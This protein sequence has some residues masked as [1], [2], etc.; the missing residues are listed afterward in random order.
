MVSAEEKIILAAISCI[1]KYGIDKTTIR[2][3]GKEAGVNSASISYYFRSKEFLMQQVMDVTLENAFDMGNFEDSRDLPAKERLVCILEGMLAG[4]MKFPNIT[5]AFF[6]ELLAGNQM[7]APVVKKCNEFIGALESELKSAYP[8]MATEDIR[9]LL[10]QAASSTF[11]FPGLFPEFFGGFPEVDFSN[12]KIRKIYVEKLIS[13][14][15]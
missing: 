3:I 11:L 15:L 10:I 1:E 8:D 9:M 13:K 4:A 14:L 2:Q 5:R 7:D 6:S 12:D